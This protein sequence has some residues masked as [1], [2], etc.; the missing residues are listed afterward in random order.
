MHDDE[1]P[2]DLEALTREDSLALKEVD[3]SHLEK[4]R[5]EVQYVRGVVASSVLVSYGGLSDTKIAVEG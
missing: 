4:T 5:R 3:T 2:F 1:M